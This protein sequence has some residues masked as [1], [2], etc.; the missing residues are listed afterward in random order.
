MNTE[1]DSRRTATSGVVRVAALGDLILCGEWA[2]AADGHPDR[3]PYADL[4]SAVNA[5]VVFANLETTLEGS[6]GRIP[7]EPR[8]LT[9]PETLRWALEKLGIDVVTLANNH[10]FDAFFSGFERT[11]GILEE[12]GVAHVGAGEDR[13]AAARHGVTETKGV[14]VG[15]LGYV[16][17]DTRPSHVASDRQFGVQTLVEDRVVGDVIRL[18]PEVDHVIVSLHWG[19]EYCHLP[20]PD[21]IRFARRIIETGATAVLGHHAHVVQGVERHGD[22]I[23]AYNLGNVTTTDFFIASRRAIRQTPRTRSSLAL[24]LDLSKPRLEGF[25]VVPIRAQDGRILVEDA[26]ARRYVDR[27]NRYV[28][29]GI[30]AAQWRRRRL[31]EDVVLRTLRKLHPA[32]VGSIRPRHV[33]KIFR[34]LFRAVHGRGPA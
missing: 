2:I 21:Q 28:R 9:T 7:K 27:A 12:L 20:S 5:D 10:T 34:N 30:S 23:I 16:A 18:R 17:A 31:L 24:C 15:W 25:E 4:R 33:G 14:R 26:V 3:D 19:V 1:S 22:G 11:R 13:A 29:R 32:V 6:E 8:I